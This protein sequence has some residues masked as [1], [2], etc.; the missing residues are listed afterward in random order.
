MLAKVPTPVF[1]RANFPLAA[2]AFAKLAFHLAT[3][4]GY[5]LFR[6]EFYYLSSTQHLAWGYVEHPPLSIALLALSRTLLGDSLF[7][8]RLL[9]A[10]AG[11]ATVILA[12]LIVREFGGGRRAEI[13]A[14]L[15]TLIMPTYL[16][17]GHFFS[18]NAFDIFF[19]AAL[20][21][22]AA[23][24]LMRE[25]SRLWLVFGVVAGIGLMNKISVGFLASGL[26]LGLLLTSQRSQ[27]M[28]PWIWLG[29]VIALL[30]FLPH[31][32]WQMQLDWPTLEFQ[33]NARAGKNLSLSAFDFFGDQA[34]MANPITLPL[35]LAGLGGLLFS[36]RLVRVRPLGFVY[37]ILF[38]LFVTQAGKTYYLT[39]IYTLLFA[40][41]AVVIEPILAWRRWVTPAL[42]AAFVVVG[43]AILPLAVP[44]LSPESFIAYTR[45][46][47]LAPPAIENQEASALPQIFA[48]MHGWQELV[49]T[50]ERVAASLPD[51]ERQ[52]ATVLA[53]NYGEA[54]ALEVL[55][56]GR[57]LPP[58]VSGHNSY[59]LW[60]PESLDGPVITLRRTRKELEPWFESIERVD[61]VRC[62]WCMPYQ[63]DSP[64]HIAR[65]LKVPFEQFRQEIKRYL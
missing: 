57:D 3:F 6:D 52:H 45:A 31:L 41:G 33:A 65:G 23:R 20:S 36:R 44:V 17:M 53:T 56:A 54:G 4:R 59:W 21:W 64:V 22:I 51:D 16:A 9:P 10:L 35:W 42:A 39:P 25:E 30:I 13:V 11:A 19:W 14:A 24:A 34:L 60:F 38:V 26:V 47:G 5:G 32:V 49:D 61:T 2:I 43:I 12:G 7:A 29:G 28:R 37:P 58:V 46:I 15:A 18:M 48:D 62:K 1:D 27:L 55:G 40:A 50:V 8:T 63:N